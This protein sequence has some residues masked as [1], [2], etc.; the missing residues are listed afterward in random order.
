MR[1]SYISVVVIRNCIGPFV[2]IVGIIAFGSRYKPFS[3]CRNK[4]IC[5]FFLVIP[6]R[7]MSSDLVGNGINSIDVKYFRVGYSYSIG[8]L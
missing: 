1:T 8:A 2:V 5:V 6:H 3:V 4:K 7:S